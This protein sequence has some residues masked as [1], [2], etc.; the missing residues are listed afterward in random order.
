MR[1]DF[2]EF[3]R[4]EPDGPHGPHLSED[5]CAAYAVGAVDT[6]TA[7]AIDRH[8][9]TCPLC[10]AKVEFLL[11]QGKVPEHIQPNLDAASKEAIK[12]LSSPQTHPTP[13]KHKALHWAPVAAILI[14]TLILLWSLDLEKKTNHL[15]ELEETARI[16]FLL[17]GVSSLLWSALLIR[18][19]NQR[20]NKATLLA[21]KE[22]KDIQLAIQRVQAEQLLD[23]AW[24]LLGG[25]PG[26][27]VITE[28]V[29]DRLRLARAKQKIDTV[30][31]IEPESR[32]ALLRLGA[33]YESVNDYSTAKKIYKKMT[34]K[35]PDFA[36]AFHNLGSLWQREA[37]HEKPPNDKKL[38]KAE[39][40]YKKAIRISSDNAA[41]YHN[42]GVIYFQRKCFDKATEVF[43]EAIAKNPKDAISLTNLAMVYYREGNYE[44]AIDYY[45][46][47]VA[48]APGSASAYNGLGCAFF[49]IGRHQEAAGAFRHAMA[50][51]PNHAYALRNLGHTF[52]RLRRS[53]QAIECFEAATNLASATHEDFFSLGCAYLDAGL[54]DEAASSFQSALSLKEDYAEAINGSGVV[55]SRKGLIAQAV[56]QF[57]LAVKIE[58]SFERARKNRA[59]YVAV[60]ELIENESTA[61]Y[62]DLCEASTDRFLTYCKLG[63]CYR[64]LGNLDA[65]KASYQEAIRANPESAKAFNELGEVFERLGQ[66]GKA[67]HCYSRAKELDPQCVDAYI[68]LAVLNNREGRPEEA[69][70]I[71]R[72]A[73]EVASPEEREAL[74]THMELVLRA[75]PQ[76]ED[77]AD[78]YHGLLEPYDDRRHV[79]ASS[80]LLN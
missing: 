51:D 71:Y 47:A 54:L 1:T 39:N 52:R 20:T 24:D 4:K 46:R 60:L 64:R 9:E 25:D 29:S 14:A 58:P 55:L 37:A 76:A 80:N 49:E 44:K 5:D 23:T 41:T 61:S 63:D 67:A 21:V 53:G 2:L 73:I 42:L 7:R 27:T 36:E 59:Q 78:T 22:T 17:I 79:L 31:R 65:S 74:E 11:D 28:P 6:G 77:S 30:L 26:K 3:L 50:L 68:S 10:A 12:F 45:R 43:Q 16:G 62:K 75:Q 19:S 18:A 56:A 34:A 33:F 72:D 70:R 57:E 48:E 8:L 13:W 38:A 35:H 32:L 15:I 66:V 69:V 40:C